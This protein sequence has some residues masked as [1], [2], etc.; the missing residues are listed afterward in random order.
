[1]LEHFNI[2]KCQFALALDIW[3][4]DELYVCMSCSFTSLTKLA[5]QY[6]YFTSCSWQ[7][8]VASIACDP[9]VWNA[10]MQNPTLM[11]FLDSEKKCKNPSRPVS[12]FQ[13]GVVP[14]A[15]SPW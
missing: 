5:M 2:R 15:F 8:V 14:S 3:S 7:T 12:S 11:E 6:I 1:M 4:L 10:V 9:N 13:I